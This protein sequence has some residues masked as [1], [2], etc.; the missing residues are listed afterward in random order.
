MWKTLKEYIP[1]IMQRWWAT[2]MFI[3]GGVLGIF[4]ALTGRMI[5]LPSW[6]WFIIGIIALFIA[7]FFTFD[8]VRKQRDELQDKLNVL[9]KSRSDVTSA[10]A[11]IVIIGDVNNSN[12]NASAVGKTQTMETKTPMPVINFID[13]K[14]Y[15]G[16]LF[17]DSHLINGAAFTHCEI[18]GPGVIWLDSKTRLDFCV[19]NWGE[20]LEAMLIEIKGPRPVTGAVG[21][22]NC[23]FEHCSFSRVGF[24]VNEATARAFREALR[25]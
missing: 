9:E 2:V 17:R 21:F 16:E 18:I 11:S 24:L 23:H 15:I 5:L 12:L 6:A 7:Q 22:T 8:K 14:L 19:F 25:R 3:I 1:S 13:K 10:L 4:T 20:S